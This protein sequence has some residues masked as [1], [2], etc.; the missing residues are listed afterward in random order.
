M[1]SP[2]LG[3]VGRGTTAFGGQRVDADIRN[4]S[5]IVLNLFAADKRKL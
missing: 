5:G 4:E 1:V 2:I 3:N